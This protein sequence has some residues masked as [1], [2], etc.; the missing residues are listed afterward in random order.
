MPISIKIP[1]WP[2]FWFGIKGNEYPFP[3]DTH[4]RVL[5]KKKPGRRKKN[6]KRQK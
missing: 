2:L 6:K 1:N 5:F 3:D 4:P